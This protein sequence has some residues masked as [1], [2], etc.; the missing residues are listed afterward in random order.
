[1]SYTAYT[2]DKINYYSESD[3]EESF[4]DMLDETVDEIVIGTLTYTASRVLEAVD[5]IAYRVGFSDYLAEFE[6]VS[7]DS[8]DEYF[9]ALNGD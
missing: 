8:E 7:F 1:M 9:T 2:D 3:L 6:E 4:R 5:P